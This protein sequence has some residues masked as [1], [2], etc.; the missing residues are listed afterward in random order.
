MAVILS[1]CPN[2]TTIA[3]YY[4]DGKEYNF[5]E[6]ANQI[7]QM[8]ASGQVVAFGLFSTDIMRRTQGSSIGRALRSTDAPMQMLNQLLRVPGACRSLRR[9]D[10]VMEDIDQDLFDLIRSRCT[11]LRSLTIRR[12]LRHRLPGIFSDQQLWAPNDNLTR[13]S[14][15]S[16]NSAY[17]PHMPL[18]VQHFRGLKELIW[19][20]CGHHHDTILQSPVD[21]WSKDPAFQPLLRRKPLLC[22]IMEH[23]VTWEIDVLSVIPAEDVTVAN[24]EERSLVNSMI[25]RVTM[26]PGMKILRVLPQ[27]PV[28]QENEAFRVVS[29]NLPAIG[30]ML[31]TLD[32]LCQD[33]GVTLIR[34]A[35]LLHPCTCCRA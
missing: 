1:K 22:L 33:S 18:L 8:I 17:A 2:A 7:V 15:M 31:P 10:L 13:L 4:R 11:Y 19:A 16:C 21:G 28:T 9:L 29:Q 14:L 20:T 3:V 35:R 34:E 6:F 24:L 27:T 30:A 32:S 26:F 5:G 12:G 23:I 25:R